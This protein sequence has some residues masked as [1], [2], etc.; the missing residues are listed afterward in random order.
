MRTLLFLFTLVLLTSCTVSR[1]HESYQTYSSTEQAFSI[2]YPDG[3][4]LT[5]HTAPPPQN[6]DQVKWTA[7]TYPAAA[8]KS[9]LLE[10]SLYVRSS[11]SCT[12]PAR[13]TPVTLGNTTF[14]KEAFSDAGAGNIYEQVI[15]ATKQDS[16][17]YTAIAYTHA[18]NLGPDCGPEHSGT[19]D[20]HAMQTKFEEILGT[21][22]FL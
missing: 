7:F 13:G 10:A 12:V 22:K 1:Y 11:D 18:C 4:T 14:Q 8:E 15:Y 20:K 2:E 9:A 17:C 21:M 6:N 5:E 3:W 19:F 16:R